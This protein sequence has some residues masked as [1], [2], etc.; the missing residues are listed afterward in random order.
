MILLSAHLDRVIQ[1]YNLQY[2]HGVH[3]GLLDNAVGILLTYL[4]LYDDANLIRLEK[5]G[6]LGIWHGK[7]E[8]WAELIDAPPAGRHDFVIVIDVAAGRQYRNMD[9]GLE[10][11][12]GV[13]PATIK[14]IQ[15][16]L[17][18]EGMRV[19]VKKYNGDPEDAD[20]AWQWR[21][22]NVPVLSF[23]VPIRAKRDGWHRVQQDNTVSA[24]TI[25]TCRQGL[26][27]LINILLEDE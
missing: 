20:E 21:N 9:F 24:E 16:V 11:I 27:R 12:A 1:D 4:T 22:K 6:R 23:I 2:R 19:R 7:G 14:H 18:W 13:K 5:Q 3:K 25:L 10:N 26:K 15:E 17:E 8:E